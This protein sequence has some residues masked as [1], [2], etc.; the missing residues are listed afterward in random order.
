MPDLQQPQE[1]AYERVYWSRQT[2]LSELFVVAIDPSE[3]AE[4][5]TFNSKDGMASCR[6]LLTLCR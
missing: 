5:Y 2:S 4:S 3:V 1:L 6:M